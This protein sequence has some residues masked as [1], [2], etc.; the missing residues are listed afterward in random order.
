MSKIPFN[1][2]NSLKN[3]PYI[4]RVHLDTDQKRILDPIKYCKI[5]NPRYIVIL[6]LHHT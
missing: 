6:F 3:N 5:V 2:F 4:I 1:I